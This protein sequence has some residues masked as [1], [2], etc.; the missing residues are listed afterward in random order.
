MNLIFHFL[1]SVSLLLSSTA[2]SE[3]QFMKA[4]SLQKQG[5]FI[6][7]KLIY[8]QLLQDRDNLNERF[9]VQTNLNLGILHR[10]LGK[11]DSAYYVF[12]NAEKQAQLCANDSLS[13]SVIFELGSMHR[14]IGNFEIAMQYFQNGLDLAKEMQSNAQIAAAML[15]IS[16]IY[17]NIANYSKAIEF[18]D[19]SERLY[20]KI[21]PF[22]HKCFGII[23]NNKASNYHAMK[24]YEKSLY[25]YKR[26][27][28]N[29]KNRLPF[30][31][32]SL[33]KSIN[34]LANNYLNLGKV[35]SAHYYLN[36]VLERSS[37]ENHQFGDALYYRG[38]L[39]SK[40]Q[41][42]E[43]AI[44]DF[45]KSAEIFLSI[46]GE[47][48][49]W[50]ASNFV[51][52]AKVYQKLA[53][54]DSALYY[55]K[56]ALIANHWDFND[57]NF[58]ANPPIDGA[59]S[60]N[61]MIEILEGKGITLWK[62]YLAGGDINYL[63]ASR[64]TFERANE[65][66]ELERRAYNSEELML[67]FGDDIAEFYHGAIAT[68]YEFFKLTG[69][70][71]YVE[72]AFAYAE[73][74]KAFILLK[75]LSESELLAQAD[76]DGGL[77]EAKKTIEDELAFFENRLAEVQNKKVSETEA[78]TEHYKENLFKLK[79][80]RDTLMSVFEVRYPHYFQTKF[81]R[82]DVNI[83]I[84]QNQ[85]LRDD[86]QLVEYVVTDR[87]IYAIVISRSASKIMAL[88]MPDTFEQRIL[89]FRK[90][91]LESDFDNYYEATTGLHE[92]LISPLNIAPQIKRIKI[93]RDGI[94]GY[95]PFEILV[96]KE[97]KAIAARDYRSLHYL[98]KDYEISYD[99]SAS[100]AFRSRQGDGSNASSGDF[101]AFAPRFSDDNDNNLIA[102]RSLADKSV[103]PLKNTI[104]E[105][106]AID[107]IF[108][109]VSFGEEKATEQRFKAIAS[110]AKILHLATHAFVDDSKPANS[111]LLFTSDSESGEDG[112]LH[113]YELY[114]MDLNADL[115]TLSACNTGFGKIWKGE[116][117]MSIARGFALAGC[118]NLVVS[119]WPA[120]DRSTAQL[121]EDFYLNL[122]KGIPVDSAL[123]AA[124]L[125]FLNR[126]DNINANPYYWGGFI[127]IGSPV[128]VELEKPWHFGW[129]RFLLG[130][131][132]LAVVGFI[133][134]RKNFS[135][136]NSI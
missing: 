52:I 135:K 5:K 81:A 92:L 96:D 18:L 45:K 127:Y 116:G 67:Y 125:A 117:V 6:D 121:M 12:E 43:P 47:A 120:S 131:I 104:K 136:T 122:S 3:K 75:S 34:H 48:N 54:H 36:I 50:Y 110:D 4:L 97:Q 132:V 42:Y 70:T 13:L 112:S 31:H 130:V 14:V 85:F 7:A 57:R 124:K 113:A 73:A 11:I 71:K 95:L 108:D 65:I 84:L 30:N 28:E 80:K 46:Y 33:L 123:H 17:Q 23:H 86:E 25:Y 61:Y 102:Y 64:L 88:T 114:N 26:A 20:S 89:I 55:Y 1:L 78:K 62:T 24:D 107:R 126:A 60:R 58:E 32:P 103:Q 51:E 10:H 74:N 29:K 134:L 82:S 100:I 105:V 63:K 119:L 27:V 38:L 76:I 109:L 19:E 40:L 93:I 16:T 66:I 79:R 128:E 9:L 59:V 39:F 44:A 15:N 72:E 56:R 129:Q 90:A 99:Y 37:S 87:R 91:L 68:A 22:D 106:E 94:L 111:H 115:V 2:D 21:Y 83:E 133:L 41:E 53:E 69:D 8:L 118:P 101:L 49:D 77:K 98:L 35:D